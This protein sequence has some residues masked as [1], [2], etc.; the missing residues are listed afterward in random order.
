MKYNYSGKLIVI[1]GT[2]A[3]GKGTQTDLLISRLNQEGLTCNKISFPT[4]GSPSGRIVGQCYLGKKKAGPGQPEWPGDVSWFGEAA[5]V[6]AKVACCYYAANRRDEL[7]DMLNTLNQGKHL[8]SDRYVESNLAHQGGKL[9]KNERLK[10]WEELRN[11]EY[12]FL[13]LPEPDKVILLVMPYKAG[14]ILKKGRDEVADG[15]EKDP[16]HLKNA[17]ETYLQ[18]AKHYGWYT[19]NC[20]RE[21]SKHLLDKLEPET[22]QNNTLEECL[23][24][25]GVSN[26]NELIKSREQIHDE[27]YRAVKKVIQ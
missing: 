26:I 19:I 6:D 3:S 16:E 1:E 27:V 25:M 8:I 14:M 18:L 22:I 21:E 23:K 24:T 2:D 9:N 12:G 17:E 10:F 11:V 20:I 15:H 4:Y 5:K 13:E 7:K